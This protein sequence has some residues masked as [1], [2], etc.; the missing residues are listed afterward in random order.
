[1]CLLL[2]PDEWE[3]EDEDYLL[4][5]KSIRRKINP[6]L[7]KIVQHLLLRHPGSREPHGRDEEAGETI[8]KLFNVYRSGRITKWIRA[9]R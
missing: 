4:T 9:K 8:A 6:M 5:S 2:E 3:A 7:G 1:M